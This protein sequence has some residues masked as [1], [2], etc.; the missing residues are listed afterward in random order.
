VILGFM[1]KTISADLNLT[2]AQGASLVTA[3]LVGAVIG[4]IGFGM[5][6]DRLGRVRVLTWTIRGKTKSR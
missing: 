2:Q 4:G 1:L 5:L 3:T 6:S